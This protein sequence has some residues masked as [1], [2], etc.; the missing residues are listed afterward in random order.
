MT[1]FEQHVTDSLARL[2]T[3]M[4]SLIG[5]GQP[6]RIAQIERKVTALIVAVIIL[7]STVLGSHAATI[8]SWF[9]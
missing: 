1:D 6:G 8:I 5:N 3:S 9:K 4:Y 2:E 7:S